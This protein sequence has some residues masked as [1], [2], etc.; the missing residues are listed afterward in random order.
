M[1]EPTCSRSKSDA[2]SMF[3]SLGSILRFLAKIILLYFGLNGN[4][5]SL[6]AHM[7]G[8]EISEFLVIM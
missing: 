5:A 3:S 1:P 7:R 8:N 6:E 4:V 2:L